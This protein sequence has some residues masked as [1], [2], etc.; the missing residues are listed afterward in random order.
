MTH[1]SDGLSAEE[2]AWAP[3]GTQ[4]L[5]TSNMTQIAGTWVMNSDGSGQ[6]FLTGNAAGSTPAVPGDAGWQPVL[7]TTSATASPSLQSA[8]LTPQSSTSLAS[9]SSTP[10]DAWATG[11]FVPNTAVSYNQSDLTLL[12]QDV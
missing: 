10:L 7:T 8:A 4:L 1:V 2:P 12:F 3:D 11:T 9:T 5:F 6:H